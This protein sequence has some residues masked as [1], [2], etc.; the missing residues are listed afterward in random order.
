MATKSAVAAFNEA[1]SQELNWWERIWADGASPSW[2]QRDHCHCIRV[3]HMRYRNRGIVSTDMY[4]RIA[5][6]VED[7]SHRPES[8]CGSGMDGRDAGPRRWPHRRP[9][10]PH[11]LASPPCHAIKPTMEMPSRTSTGT[12][13]GLRVRYESAPTQFP[14][15]ARTVGQSDRS[16]EAHWD[17][18]Q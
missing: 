13:C 9:L 3:P 17:Q 2:P 12:G 10:R 18:R 4:L 8:S 5:R 7:R 16:R 6:P 15:L 11:S 1:I 14:G